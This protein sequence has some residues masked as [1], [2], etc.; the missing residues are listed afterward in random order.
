MR[1]AHGLLWSF[2][3]LVAALLATLHLTRSDEGR[4]DPSTPDQGALA[5]LPDRLPSSLPLAT[6]E[7]GAGSVQ[8][9]AARDGTVAV[10]MDQSWYLV[11]NDSVLG[12]FGDAVAGAPGW[13]SRPVSIAIA[14]DGRTFVLDAGRRAVSVWGANGVW[15]G[16]VPVPGGD[17]APLPPAQV[18]VGPSDQAQV[19]SLQIDLDGDARWVLHGLGPEGGAEVWFSIAAR[20]GVAVFDRPLLAYHDGRL[21]GVNALD[22]ASFAWY[23]E[24]DGLRPL[25]RRPEPPLWIVPRRIRREHQQMISAFGGGAPAAYSQ[26]PAMWPSVRDV[27]V[28]R[29]GSVLMLVTAGE[30][31]QHIELLT[32]ALVPRWRF[33]A[34]GFTE[35]VFLDGGRAFMVEV[36]MAETVISEFVING[37]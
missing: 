30:D 12:P 23:P 27:T 33:N 35:P 22:H 17:G 37:G 34:E 6:L 2:L 13:L 20:E 19:L 3:A 26:L 29:D 24:G 32:A 31:R 25:G 9:V 4:E 16:D 1:A 28:R 11:R 21:H 7:G 15:V 14:S 18:V 36:K 8:D 10:L 5:P